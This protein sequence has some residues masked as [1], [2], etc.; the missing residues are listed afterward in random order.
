MSCLSTGQRARLSPS[1][2]RVLFLLRPRIRSFADPPPLFLLAAWPPLANLPTTCLPP[3]ILRL[4]VHP[5]I[6]PTVPL[7]QPLYFRL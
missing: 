6:L 5:W 4:I 2:L 3:P 7:T 1:P